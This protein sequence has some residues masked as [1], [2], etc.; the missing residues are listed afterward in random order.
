MNWNGADIGE[1]EE[2]Q[3]TRG[4][5]RRVQEAAGGSRSRGGRQ[6]GEKG[7]SLSGKFRHAA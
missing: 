7:G 1:R 3:G 4:N 6:G 2:E 5:N